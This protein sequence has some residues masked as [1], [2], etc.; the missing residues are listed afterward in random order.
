MSDPI[1]TPG[2]PRTSQALVGIILVLIAII[3]WLL[4]HRGPTLGPL[5]N[6]YIP[7]TT[8]VDAMDRNAG[9]GKKVH[10]YVYA[11]GY[12]TQRNQHFYIQ[13]A[14]NNYFEEIPTGSGA[15]E[16]TPNADPYTLVLT[17]SSTPLDPT[18]PV[19]IMVG[20]EQTGPFT[21]SYDSAVG[22]TNLRPNR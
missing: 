11:Q 8:V 16:E 7:Q 4:A 19:V 3:A 20:A 12:G 1:P 17:R 15:T 6:G 18:K 22:S 10:F 13:D 5:S 2:M 14:G 21:P 9:T